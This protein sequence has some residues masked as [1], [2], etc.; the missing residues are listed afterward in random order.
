V[1]PETY[2]GI[3]FDANGVCNHCRTHRA[4]HTLGREALDKLVEARRSRSGPYDSIVALSGGRDSTYVAHY[5]TKVLGLKPLLYTFD[6]GMMPEQTVE[7]VAWTAR[8]LGL[9]HVISKSDDVVKNAK[10]IM[11]CWVHKPSPAMIGLLCSGCRTGYVRGLAKTARK[12]GIALVL[13]G[14]GEPERSFAQLLL[15]S[16]NQRNKK[17]S[18]VAGMARQ[19]LENPRY[20]ANPAFIARLGTEFVYRFY[21]PDRKVVR[22]A[23]LFRFIPWDEET[24]VSTIE[25]ELGWK[26]AAYTN[27][28]WRSDCT[29][30]E[31][32]N[33][34]YKRT[35][36]F[37]KNDELVSGMIR[38][39][40]LTRQEA[41]ERLDSDNVSSR[42]FIARLCAELGVNY[43]ALENALDI[44]PVPAAMA[45]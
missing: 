2:P 40:L 38:T 29:V 39:D 44:Y 23:A 9:D 4:R 35:L 15:S 34:L 19:W 6:N 13:T 3:H 18:L 25:Q 32:K 28:T 22:S 36:G 30:N 20:A 5:A 1:L 37:T 8:K 21:R 16:T 41:L 43:Q 45:A 42:A 10:H 31:L 27:A 26:K 17:L 14:G 33:Y 12:H 24:I 11:S 7:N